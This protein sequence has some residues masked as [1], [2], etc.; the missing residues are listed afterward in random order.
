MRVFECSSRCRACDRFDEAAVLSYF[1]RARR[2]SRPTQDIPLLIDAT[3]VWRPSGICV[4]PWNVPPRAVP[5]HRDRTI[6]RRPITI[7]TR[8]PSG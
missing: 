4:R 1:T 8:L 2:S 5:Q 7:S 6:S 3:S